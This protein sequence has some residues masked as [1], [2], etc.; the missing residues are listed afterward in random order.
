MRV[1]TRLEDYEA[2]STKFV[3]VKLEHGRKKFYSDDLWCTDI[4]PKCMFDTYQKA[5]DVLQDKGYPAN[6]EIKMIKVIVV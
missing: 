3:I 6:M 4:E 2:I 5:L 1:I